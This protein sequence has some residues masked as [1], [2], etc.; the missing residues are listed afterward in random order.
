[1]FET[2][3]ERISTAW[4][5]LKLIREAL[6]LIRADWNRLEPSELIGTDLGLYVLDRNGLVLLGNV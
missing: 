3:S 5:C 2:N 1:M 4:E 6:G